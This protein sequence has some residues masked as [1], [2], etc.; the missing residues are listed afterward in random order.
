MLTAQNQTRILQIS[1]VLHRFKEHTKTVIFSWQV[2]VR[3]AF[4]HQ[5]GRLSPSCHGLVV[6]M[7]ATR[8]RKE[9]SNPEMR[10]FSYASY[11]HNLG[12]PVARVGAKERQLNVMVE[13][14]AIQ[15]GTYR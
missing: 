5:Y 13:K 12:M 6:D 4:F 9:G 8:P 2:Y 7:I 14:K 1:R 11:S 15:S 3:F 10:K